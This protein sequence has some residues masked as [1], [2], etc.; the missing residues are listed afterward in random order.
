MRCHFADLPSQLGLVEVT[1][2]YRESTNPVLYKFGHDCD[3]LL[4]QALT[5]GKKM[6]SDRIIKAL[7]KLIR[8]VR[9]N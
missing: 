2:P 7:E 6:L 9:S 8:K 3:A 4:N 1:K 5:N